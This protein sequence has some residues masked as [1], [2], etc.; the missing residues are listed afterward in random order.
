VS[1][2]YAHL[3]WTGSPRL[4]LG[5]RFPENAGAALVSYRS[6][7]SSGSSHLDDFDPLGTA[8]LHTRLNL[9]SLDID[10]VGADL[11]FAPFWDLKWQLGVRVAGVYYSTQA[12]G[13]VREQRANN[14][15]VGAGPHAAIGLERELEFLPGFAA[16]GRLDGAVVVGNDS[17]SFEETDLLPGGGQ[18]GG[19]SRFSETRSSPMLGLQLGLSYAPHCDPHWFRFSFGYQFEQWWGVGSAGGNHGDV[20]FQGLF[21]RGEFNY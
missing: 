16:Y 8:F 14:N 20:R 12:V 4:E 18:V 9:N 15:F 1:L 2:P 19:A 11:P 13:Q 3:A 5:Y 17:Q 21:F 6:V 10:Y 7:V